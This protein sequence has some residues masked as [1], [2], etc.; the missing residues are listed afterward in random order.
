MLF[1]VLALLP[2]LSLSIQEI[3][4]SG[5]HLCLRRGWRYQRGN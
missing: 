4:Y 5:F 3:S 2:C 1:I